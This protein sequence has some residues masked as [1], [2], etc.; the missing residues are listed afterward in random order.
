MRRKVSF[1]VVLTFLVILG[2]VYYVNL[3]KKYYVLQDFYDFPIPKE[4][5]LESESENSKNYIWEPST[6]TG[7]P[8]SYRLV[9]KKNGWKQTEVD[10]HSF[11]FKKANNVISI[12]VASDY[13]G[14]LK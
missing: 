14:I 10:G 8:I 11:I 9:I 12:V 2:F 3:D 5:V 7:L 1:L 13:I 6:G 4:A